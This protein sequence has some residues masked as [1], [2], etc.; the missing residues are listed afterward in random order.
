M[1]TAPPEILRRPGSSGN[2]TIRALLNVSGDLQTP[3]GDLP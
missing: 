1:P 3:K 2:P